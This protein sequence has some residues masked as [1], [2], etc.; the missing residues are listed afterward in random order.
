MLAIA[1]ATETDT[2]TKKDLEADES[3]YLTLGAGLPSFSYNRYYPSASYYTTP[4]YYRYGSPYAYDYGYEPYRR[5][6][7]SAFG[8]TVFV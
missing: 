4:E 2:E 3:V 5:Y 1:C 6:Y 7:S 8:R